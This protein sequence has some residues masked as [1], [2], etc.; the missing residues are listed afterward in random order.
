MGKK[1]RLRQRDATPAADGSVPPGEVGPR[2]PCPCGSGRRFKHCHGREGGAVPYVAR[3]FEGLPGECDLVALREIVPAA[4]APLPLR[5]GLADGREVTVCTL[6]PMAT[7]AVVRADGSVW[8]GLQVR[9]NFG[10]ISRDLA[11]TLELAL[12]AEPGSQIGLEA[13]PPPGPRL[14]DLVDPA[15]A[16][17]VTVHDGFDFWIAGAEDPGGELAAALQ[18]AND[19]AA[20]TSRLTSVE[21]AY[22][23]RM[24]NHEFVRWVLP[25]EEGRVLDALARMHAAGEDRLGEDGRLL[26]MFRSHGL[27][28]PVWELPVGAGPEEFDRRLGEAAGR[29]DAALADEAPLTAEQRAA[30]NGLATRQLTIR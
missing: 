20:P 1:A 25:H 27:V 11:H 21:A 19:A 29:L 30:R 24:G 22:W 7:P 18:S 10:D 6:L 9:A 8:L 26:G 5:A 14:Q 23:T 15:G 4:T 17:P 16:L 28:A 2:Q 13:P 3:T 12:A